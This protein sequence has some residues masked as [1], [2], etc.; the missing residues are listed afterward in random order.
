MKEARA[1]HTSKREASRPKLENIEVTGKKAMK[2]IRVSRGTTCH[3]ETLYE[4]SDA[5]R[6]CYEEEEKA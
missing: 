3:S 6:E 2:A 5:I 1:V 4:V